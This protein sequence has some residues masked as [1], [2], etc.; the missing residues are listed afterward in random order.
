M[1]I[2]KQEIKEYCLSHL[3][4]KITMMN[5]ALKETQDSAN[6]DTK[7]SAGDK[8]E[9]SRAMAH[10]E[11]ERLAKQLENL[12]NLK[13]AVV[14]LDASENSTEVSLGSYVVTNQGDFYISVGLGKLQAKD[15]QF[16]AIAINSPVGQQ[17]KGKKENESF[18]FSGIENK[19]LAIY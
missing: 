7:S 13:T 10:I 19:I 17:L 6:S 14:K 5:N 11:N 16:F 9:T 15:N 8:H 2:N 4:D 18:V 3:D 1:K 12:I